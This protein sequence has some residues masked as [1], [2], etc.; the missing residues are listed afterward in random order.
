[1]DEGSSAAKK[2]AFER[3]KYRHGGIDQQDFEKIP[4]APIAY[5]VPEVVVS[6]FENNER[7]EEIAKPRV[8]LQTGDNKRFLRHWTEVDRNYVLL[9]CM[10]RKEA[11]TVSHKWFPYNKGGGYR[12]WYGN[13]DFVVNWENDG[14]E[15]VEY[16]SSL[17]KSASRTVKNTHYYFEEGITWSDVSSGAFA[18][19]HSPGG[20]IF[21]VQGSSAFPDSQ[22]LEYLLGYLNSSVVTY[23]LHV[24]NPTMHYQVGNIKNL[25]VQLPNGALKQQV[26]TGVQE[27]IRIT[28]SDWNARETSWDFTQHPIVQEGGSEFKR[29]YTDWR[30]R[31]AN[32]FLQLKGAEEELNRLFIDLYSLQDEL[33][34]RVAL[35]D[36]T[37]LED[38]L[39]RK[40][41]AELDEERDA[42]TDDELR[43][44]LPFKVEV[45][46]QQFISY[47][48]GVMLGRY[49][50]GHD[51][52]HIAHPDATAEEE[53]PYE[54]P[55]P[56]A[57]DE[58]EATVPFEIDRD[59][60]LPLMGTDSPFSDDA[61]HRMREI[62][63]LVWGE[64]TLTDNLNFINRAL[65]EGASRGYARPKEQTMEA[66][67][68]EEFW[69][70]HKSLYSV[71]YYGK[72]PIYWLFAS[73]KRHF[74]V[75][76]YMHRMT[77]YTAQQ[78]RQ[79][80]LHTYQQYLRGEIDKLEARGES[81]LSNTEAKR[82]DLLRAKAADCRA[83]DTLLKPVADQQIEID[84]DDG[85]QENYPK[86]GD[87]V[88]PL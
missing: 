27:C 77:K 15:I 62:L 28:Q 6:A 56:L 26:E 7:L 22:N 8:G 69:D 43:E 33:S 1:V 14:E 76:V 82:L 75:L 35:N 71:P 16:A 36:V 9:H 38:E 12:K 65:S 45:P 37:I 60:I 23:A 25:P 13:L 61:V 3:G 83:Y 63:R 5:W 88:A 34:P 70:Y 78:V 59:G 21:D 50:L 67:L 58:P 41:L 46:I 55:V 24:L 11:R 73:P 79:N 2:E 18:C 84:L 4:G 39:D 87:A 42:L 53:A 48:V 54:V 40:A 32:D 85:V 74:Q 17:Y 72:K 49:R 86:F 10:S 80:Y 30:Q 68:V 52:L 44:R 47:G 19:R 57:A 31:T 20:L 81:Q 66:W 29:A 64:D 51:G